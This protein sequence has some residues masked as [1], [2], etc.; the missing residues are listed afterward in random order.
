[1]Q[2]PTARSGTRP[3]GAASFGVRLADT[4]ALRRDGTT[5]INQIKVPNLPQFDA[6]LGA[7]ARGTLLQSENGQAAIEDLRPG[8]KLVT[9]DGELSEIVWIGS[10]TF[11]AAEATNR[12]HITRIMA[13]SFGVNRPDSFLSLGPAARVL[14]TPP[15]LRS[16]TGSLRMMTPAREFVDGV[17]VIE[18]TPPTPVRLFHISLRR[19]AA[20][21]AGGLEVETFHPGPQPLQNLSH[22]L[23]SVYMGLFPHINQI[24]DFGPM[25]HPRAPEP[26]VGTRASA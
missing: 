17:N 6:A 2:N 14:Q 9:T 1:M 11:S 23:R 24:S 10:S 15:H 12:V 4:A 16:E 25:V 19:H 3:K 20:I 22:T 21:L 13:D 18:V 7:F 5:A 26:I 8:D